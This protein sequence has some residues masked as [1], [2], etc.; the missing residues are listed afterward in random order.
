M[1]ILEHLLAAEAIPG[2][3]KSSEFD[4]FRTSLRNAC[5]ASITSLP[6]FQILKIQ[7]DLFSSITDKLIESMDSC[8]CIV[9]SRHMVHRRSAG[10]GAA[11]YCAGWM[12]AHVSQ[13]K[14]SRKS[15]FGHGSR[16]AGAKSSTSAAAASS[17]IVNVSVS[18]TQVRKLAKLIGSRLGNLDLHDY[19][20]K[21]ILSKLNDDDSRQFRDAL[22]THPNLAFPTPTASLFYHVLNHINRDFV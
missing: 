8:V 22:T 7:P 12:S 6:M 15:G 20:L 13:I 9:M 1:R 18:L 14:S 5:I 16:G 3:R 2:Y 10:S 4:S 19:S 11:G 21:A 17:V